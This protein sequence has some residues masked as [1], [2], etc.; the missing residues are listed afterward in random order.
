MPLVDWMP[1]GF[2]I[3][4]NNQPPVN[5]E[6]DEIAEYERNFVMIGN[7]CGMENISNE[8]IQI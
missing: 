3:A 8:N 5:T 6:Y 1:T 2:K 4:L 7:C